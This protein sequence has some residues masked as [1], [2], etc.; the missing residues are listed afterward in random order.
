M[1]ILAGGTCIIGIH[2]D[3]ADLWSN[4]RVQP[5]IVATVTLHRTPVQHASDA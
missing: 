2:R 4:I 1:A 5:A 3:A